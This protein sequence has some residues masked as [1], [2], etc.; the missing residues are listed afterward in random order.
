MK[1][2]LIIFGGKS[3]EYDIS[4]RSVNFVI[5]NISADYTLVGIDKCGE[6]YEVKKGYIDDNWK[7]NILFKVNNIL[8]Y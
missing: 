3:F 1:K 6:W 5:N 8:V 4:L 2:V 7:N